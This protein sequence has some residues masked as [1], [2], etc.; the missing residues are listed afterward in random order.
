MNNV[1]ERPPEGEP[2]VVH[3]TQAGEPHTWCGLS[4]AALAG[5]PD[6]THWSATLPIRADQIQVGWLALGFTAEDGADLVTGVADCTDR[7]CAWHGGCVVISAGTEPIHFAG[8]ATMQVRIPAAVT[9]VSAGIAA[10]VEQLAELTAVLRPVAERLA[11]GT[12]TSPAAVVQARPAPQDRSGRPRSVH[13]QPAPGRAQGARSGGR[14]VNV[15]DEN[16]QS[17][18]SGAGTGS[19]NGS[20]SGAGTGTGSSSGA[21]TGTGNGGAGTGSGR[22]QLAAAVLVVLLGGA[23]IAAAFV[24]TWADPI[25]AHGRTCYLVALFAA[26]AVG[27]QVLVRPRRIT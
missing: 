4:L 3:Y 12:E 18:G 15:R 24:D 7:T 6:A 16:T 5:T 10:L 11:A 17:S 25:R 21:G 2:V 27:D 19:G 22:V 8:W 23:A 26:Y 20:S 14:L 9:P 1:T 13:R